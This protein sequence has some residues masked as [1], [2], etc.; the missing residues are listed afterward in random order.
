MCFAQ[1][2]T[3]T[4]QDRCILKGYTWSPKLC[5]TSDT[6][7]GNCGCCFKTQAPTPAPTPKPT[8]C[9]LTKMCFAQNG[10]CTQQD[11]CILKGYTWSPKLCSTSDT[12]SG[13]CGCC[14]K[15]RA[16]TP[17]PTPKPTEMCSASRICDLIGGKCVGVDECDLRTHMWHDRVCKDIKQNRRTSKKCGCC[18]PRPT[19]RPTK[20]PTT[21]PTK[22]PTPKKQCRQTRTCERFGGKCGSKED[23]NTKMN[24][25]VPRLCSQNGMKNCG[26]CRPKP[27][28]RPTPKPTP[29]PTPEPNSVCVANDR[30]VLFGGKCSE[31][32]DC[33][34]KWNIW[35]F[36]ECDGNGLDGKPCGC[37]RPKICPQSRTCA[38]R[39][40]TC[41]T[42]NKCDFEKG[43]WVRRWCRGA[44]CGCCVPNPTNSP[45]LIFTAHPIS[46]VTKAPAHV[47]ARPTPKPTKKIK[48]GRGLDEAD[49]N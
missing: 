22:S 32:E 46:M 30:C 11:R 45:T 12:V 40:G 49:D 44:S 33:D 16:P 34:R 14:F 10:T 43:R 29:K 13:N 6:V 48:K 25:W 35:N 4:Q 17:A 36:R 24:W 8:T 27:T 28:R 19:R 41:V 9:S 38:A 23:C 15:T 21:R 39:G 42:K 37:C 47:I 1:N 31:R 20:S 26:C 3:C 7:S 2:G 18:R 5:S